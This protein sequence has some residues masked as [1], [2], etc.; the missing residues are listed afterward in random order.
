MLG[1]ANWA[2]QVLRQ[3]HCVWGWRQP[4]E[5][6]WSRRAVQEPFQW[7]HAPVLWWVMPMMRSYGTLAMPNWAGSASD[8]AS[9]QPCT[10]R[11][12]TLSKPGVIAMTGSPWSPHADRILAYPCRIVAVSLHHM[13]GRGQ[14]RHGQ[15]CNQLPLGSGAE[16]LRLAGL[17][18][19]HVLAK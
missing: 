8:C 6:G 11:Q 14:H 19:W 2:G 13:E 1:K 10:C 9:F 3:A 18:C 17:G 16:R 4:A 15:H 5:C 7:G 12:L